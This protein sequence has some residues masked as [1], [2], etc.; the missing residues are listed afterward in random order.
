MKR[1][2]RGL[3]LNKQTGQFLVVDKP[4]RNAPYGDVKIYYAGHV[5]CYTAG[6][7]TDTGTH[8]VES[9]YTC[10]KADVRKII[11]NN[12]FKYLGHL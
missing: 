3:F 4:E 1:F 11:I 9:F 5:A 6:S 12:K 10:R 8:T 2:K 7:D